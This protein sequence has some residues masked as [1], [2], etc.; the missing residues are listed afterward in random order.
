MGHFI[1]DALGFALYVQLP[2][3]ARIEGTHVNE[4]LDY[5]EETIFMFH[6]ELEAVL[7]VEKTKILIPY[8]PACAE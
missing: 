2:D 8:L 6:E 7:F 3:I 1:R 4:P 5:R